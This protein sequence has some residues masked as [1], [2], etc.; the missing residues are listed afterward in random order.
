MN[1]YD[2]MMDE[3][4]RQINSCFAEPPIHKI[5]CTEQN[6]SI[7]N[8]EA[9]RIVKEMIA[10]GKIFVDKG[11]ERIYIDSDIPVRVLT[12]MPLIDSTLY[13]KTLWV[14]QNKEKIG[15]IQFIC[16]IEFPISGDGTVHLGTECVFTPAQPIEQIEVKGEIIL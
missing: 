12:F 11:I 15:Y 3:L 13:G 16:D 10:F 8:E 2:A 4:K 7:L 1:E 9:V 5:P 14:W 6:V